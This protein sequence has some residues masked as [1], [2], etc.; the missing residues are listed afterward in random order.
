MGATREVCLS[1]LE[2]YQDQRLAD[3]VFDLA[4]THSQVGLRQLNVT[5]ADAQ[6]YE[7]LASSVLYANPSLRAESSILALNRRGQSGLWGH[8]RELGGII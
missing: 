4:W 2:K 1:L 5:E 7:R 6:L 3:R 8:A